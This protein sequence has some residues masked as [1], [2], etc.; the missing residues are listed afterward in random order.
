M[1]A[2]ILILAAI[3]AQADVPPVPGLCTA[4]VPADHDTPGCYATGRIEIAEAPDAL[5]W[6]IHEF[7]T[8]S[9]ATAEAGR[10]R[11]ATVTQA[12]SRTWLYVLGTPSEPITGGTRRATIGPLRMLPGPVTA[13]F[14]EA[15]FPPG[16][17][18][19]VHS[20][21]GPEAFYVVEGEQCMDSPGD[22]RLIPAGGTYVVE[23][24]PHLQAAPKGRRNLVLILAPQG[25]PPLI[26]G[27]DWRP[28][29]FC[30]P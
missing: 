5:Y 30:R 14:A 9:A 19:R 10:H 3:V 23:G 24:G 21:P 4:P 29:G 15:I 17:Q 22:K 25:K 26:P 11:W 16:M 28:T 6:Q 13:H 27:G 20:H 1:P 7:P 18:T 12:H 2:L 8:M